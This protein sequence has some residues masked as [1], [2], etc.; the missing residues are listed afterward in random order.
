PLWPMGFTLAGQS[1][2]LTASVSGMILLG[3]SLGGTVLPWLVGQAIEVTGPQALVYLVFG[4]LVCHGL[5]FVA[6]LRWRP[7]VNRQLFVPESQ[8]R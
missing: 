1:L 8:C 3:D 4:S 5:A 2:T 7:A 6:M